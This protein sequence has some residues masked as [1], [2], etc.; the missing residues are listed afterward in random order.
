MN[1]IIL[2][3]GSE[4]IIEKPKLG[5]GNPYNDYGRGFYCTESEELAKEWACKKNNDGYVNRY[6]LNTEGLREL[7]L[8]DSSHSIL[9]WISTLLQ[10]RS[11]RLDSPIANDTR[12]YLTE[13]FAIDTSAFDII[14]GYR[15]DD[16]YFQYAAAFVEN[17]LP[18]RSLNRALKLGNLGLQTVL[19][20]EKAFEQIHFINAEP[21]DRTI[22]Y[23]KF[24]SR[25]Q[26]ARDTY[27]KDVRNGSSYRED[28]FAIDILREEMRSDDARI[29]RILSE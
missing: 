6:S 27:K 28:I 5:K 20:S 21:V 25:D 14:T 8:S 3:H 10:N 17:S 7:V 24:Y 26:E 4:Q 15:A 2:L 22:Y 16:S 29:Q 12:D 9:N 18:L 13:H 1:S 23:P 19:V 11:F